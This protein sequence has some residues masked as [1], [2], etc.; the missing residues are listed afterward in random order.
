[1]L[2]TTLRPQKAAARAQPSTFARAPSATAAPMADLLDADIAASRLQGPEQRPPPLI[3]STIR[4][5]LRDILTGVYGPGDR[6]RE[7]EVAE[8]FGISRAPVREALRVLEQDGLVVIAPFRGASVIDP[9][10]QE[11]ADLFD[12][13]GTVYG[14]MARFAVRHS[15]DA[16]LQR[17]STDVALFS[18]AVAEGRDSFYLV[19]IA[20][21]AGTDLG[22]SCGSPIAAGMMRRLGRVAYWLHSYLLPVP[23]RWQMQGATKFRRLEQALLARSEEKSETAARKLVQHTRELLVQHA[24]QAQTQ[25][26]LS[27]RKPAQHR[28]Q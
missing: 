8:R 15:S 16:D 5:L 20:Y 13:L 17:F 12:L 3:Q 23:R 18:R 26:V 21:R 4:R 19:D 24:L 10:P 25:T 1:M 27:A 7:A 14:A 22:E 11:I 2:N 28:S 9:S 6:I